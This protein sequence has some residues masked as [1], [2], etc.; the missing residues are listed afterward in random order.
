MALQ[1]Q[2]YFENE[3][4]GWYKFIKPVTFSMYD[5]MLEFIE[6]NVENPYRHCRWSIRLDDEKIMTFVSAFKF[7]YERDYI[8]FILRFS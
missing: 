2:W 1:E 6:Q 5:E 8:S 7:R 4:L 3:K